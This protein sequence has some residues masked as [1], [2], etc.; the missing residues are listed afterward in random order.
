MSLRFRLNLLI[1]LLFIA[2]LCAGSSYAIISARKTVTEEIQSVALL[3][4]NMLTASIST[5]Q[6]SGNQGLYDQLLSEL[7]KLETTRHLQILIS[8]D[9]GMGS[10]PPAA[11]D[12]AH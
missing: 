8:F 2:V 7:S 5:I 9:L 12:P 10:R 1:T 6:S 11:F 3:T 4:S